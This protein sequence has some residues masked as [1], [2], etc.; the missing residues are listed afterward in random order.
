MSESKAM[1]Q[2]PEEEWR[3]LRTKRALA[4][5][6]WLAFYSLFAYEMFAWLPA[7]KLNVY[8][9][10]VVASVGIAGIVYFYYF[11]M[12]LSSN[13]SRAMKRM[14]GLMILIAL[15]QIGFMLQAEIQRWSIISPVLNNRTGAMLIGMASVAFGLLLFFVRLK[16][17]FV[18]GLTE[19]FAGVAVAIQRVTSEVTVPSSLTTGISLG[20][21]TAGVYLIVRGIDNVHQSLFG[22]SP[23]PIAEWLLATLT[24]ER[25]AWEVKRQQR[26]VM[27]KVYVNQMGLTTQDREDM[28]IKMTAMSD[29]D[30]REMGIV[31]HTR[32]P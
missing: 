3:R 8:I 16:L 26:R 27:I 29:E 24:G 28:L 14:A 6:A 2:T 31:P 7:Q 23:D 15:F 32:K 22:S 30:L 11:Q 19:V 4:L 9:Q 20:F 10:L 21:L 13:S 5:M 1:S 18:Y 17:R 25:H 12:L